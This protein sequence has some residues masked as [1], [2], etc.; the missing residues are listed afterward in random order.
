M[1]F[2]SYNYLFEPDSSQCSFYGYCK[3]NSCFHSIFIMKMYQDPFL[4][5]NQ[6]NV[7]EVP[8]L[9]AIRVVSKSLYDLIII[10]GKLAVKIN[11]ICYHK[12]L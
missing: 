2:Y 11:S 3:A 4:K 5:P 12:K 10:N 9:C 1:N 6:A 7:M 8:G